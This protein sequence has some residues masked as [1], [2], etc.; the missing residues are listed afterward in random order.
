MTESPTPRLSSQDQDLLA[1]LSPDERDL[2]LWAIA[3]YPS[4]AIGGLV[5]T[6]MRRCHRLRHR[7]APPP[8][9]RLAGAA[10]APAIAVVRHVAALPRRGSAGSRRGTSQAASRGCRQRKSPYSVR[11]WASRTLNRHRRM[12]ESDPMYG[13]AV[14]CKRT[15]SS[16]RMRSCINVSG[17]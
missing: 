7:R 16:G 3:T 10:D 4:Q 9:S 15:S 1:Q 11:F 14:R 8:T 6:S 12:T 2:V 17:L 5:L 13:P